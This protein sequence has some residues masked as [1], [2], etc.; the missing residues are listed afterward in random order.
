ML[1]TGY[2]MLVAGCLIL[3]AGCCSTKESVKEEF[4]TKTSEFVVRVP[5]VVDTLDAIIDTVS[6]AEDSIDSEVVMH[7]DKIE[8]ADT[9]ISIKYFP[10]KKKFIVKVNPPDVPVTDVDTTKVYKVNKVY[11]EPGF[12]EKEF[13]Y[14]AG[15]LFLAIVLIAIVKFKK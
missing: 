13:W 3:I 1:D 14:I 4:E 15:F 6:A 9:S 10:K 7:A 5:P 12:F 8:N 11:K 2:W